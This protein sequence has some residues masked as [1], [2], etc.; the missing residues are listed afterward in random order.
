MVVG[1]RL[2]CGALL[3]AAPTLALADDK[4]KEASKPKAT[5]TAKVIVVDPDGKTT[6]KTLGESD[7]TP[8]KG[9]AGVVAGKA[10]IVLSDGTTKEIE[11]PAAPLNGVSGKIVMIGPD[12]AKVEKTFGE[13]AAAEPKKAIVSKVK[14]EKAD[15]FFFRVGPDGKVIAAKEGAKD[16]EGKQL[17][18]TVEAKRD[19]EGVVNLITSMKAVGPVVEVPYHV[20]LPVQTLVVKEKTGEAA[21]VKA[22]TPQ[23]TDA[24]LDAI[25]SRLEKLEKKLE[26]LERK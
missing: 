8:S 6:E 13:G 5:I 26:A 7:F 12:G 3:C 19:L 2:L 23:S 11:F 14:T 22:V 21:V 10:V 15:V 18:V 25:L 16:K 1:I 20:N 9:G 24:K 4:P 17:A